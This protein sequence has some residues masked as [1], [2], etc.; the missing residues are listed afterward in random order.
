MVW[1][2]KT[3]TPW[4]GWENGPWDRSF[5]ADLLVEKTLPK[6]FSQDLIKKIKMLR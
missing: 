3:W 5:R 4:I 6:E 2:D 1:I